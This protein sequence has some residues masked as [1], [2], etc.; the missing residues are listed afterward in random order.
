M[1]DVLPLLTLA[2]R[3]EQD[4]VHCRQAAKRLAAVLDWPVLEQIR[5]ATA[6]S[7]LA[8]NIHQY[9]GSGHFDFAL[10]RDEGQR[11]H[12]LEVWA[13]DQG[14]GIAEMEAIRAGSY[15][16]STGMGIGLRGA[17]RLFDEFDIQ[18]SPAGTRISARKYQAPRAFP[19]AT[20]LQALTAELQG[21]PPADPYQQ[22]RLQS[23]ELLLTNTELQLRQSELEVTNKELENTNQGVVA[24]YSEL[25]KATQELKEASEAK[26]R[27]FSNMTH[28]FRTPINIIENVAKLLASGVDGALNAEQQRQVRFISDAALELANLVSELLALAEVQSGRL[29]IVPQPFALAPFIDRLEQFAAALAPRYPQV[30]FSVA[31]PPA[32]VLLDTDESRLFQVLRNLISNAFKYTPQGQVRIQ[33]FQPDDAS[34]EFLVE[35]SGIGIAAADQ[36][37]IF[38]E[39]ER[40]RSP[41][42]TH[43]EGTGLGLPLAQRLAVLL[44][45]ELSLDSAVGRGSRFTLRLPRHYASH[46]EAAP[47][48]DLSGL[49]VLVIEDNE[50]DRYLVRRTLERLNPVLL[51]ADSARSSLDRLNAVR[52]DIIILDLDLPDINGEDL[53]ASM[54]WSM[55]RRVLINT[56]QPLDEAGCQRLQDYCH[57]I[58][59][60]HAPDHAER[61]LAEVCALARSLSDD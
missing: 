19:E 27:F 52:P 56:A 42:L 5:L 55:H 30:S 45:G 54:D 29:T 18:T 3:S 34:L 12:G 11:L 9:A 13:V 14:P 47:E 39:F 6:V 53:L 26:T 7:E 60:K 33:V 22:I 8:R 44:G 21:S 31:P 20:L 57:A 17:Q 48:P 25:E 49:T 1:S 16:S 10:L 4:I 32:E 28:E 43:I 51:E 36:Q 38:E 61:L 37:K 58:L 35:D 50:G 2:L 23:E 46:R 24:L 40:I 15:R 59:F 41:H